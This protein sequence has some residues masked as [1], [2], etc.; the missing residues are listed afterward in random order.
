MFSKSDDKSRAGSLSA[1]GGPARSASG[2]VVPSLVS[3][4]LKVVGN[5]ESAGDLQ[6]DG[7]V[8][9]DVKSRSVTVGESA[10]V[11]GS[12]SAETLRIAGAVDGQIRS[13]SVTVARTGKVKGDIFHQTLSIEAGATIEGQIRRLDSEK[14]NGGAKAAARP[15]EPSGA[16][17]AGPNGGGDKPAAG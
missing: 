8:K 16:A 6:I 11:K 17:K 14:P 9:G 13:T 3:A 10:K 7:E 2:S 15:V 4:D 1:P 12:I 5:L